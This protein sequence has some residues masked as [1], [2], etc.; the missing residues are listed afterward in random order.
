MDHPNHSS[1]G[2]LLAV[3]GA[4]AA[5][6]A[7]APLAR[8]SVTGGFEQTHRDLSVLYVDL[9]LIALGGALLP[10][11]VWMAVL[12]GRA[13]PWVALVA[14][15]AALTLGIW[16]LTSWWEPYQQPEF[17]GGPLRGGAPD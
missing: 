9:P 12:R 11:L 13:R 1:A 6:L 3:A 5:T 7:W 14:A 17:L 16:G 15:V 4:A 2:C 8:V 10:L